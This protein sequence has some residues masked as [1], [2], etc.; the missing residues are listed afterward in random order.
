MVCL[1]KFGGIQR[2]CVPDA[3]KIVVPARG[4]LRAVGT[5]LKPTDLAGV[6]GQLGRLVLGNA[7]VVIEDEAAAG[8]RGQDMLVPAE[9]PHASIVTVHT[10]QFCALLD[11][12]D[13]NF[14]GAQADADISAVAAPLDAANVRVRRALK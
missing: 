1:G 4:E 12:P 13:L 2:A 5:P 3:D 11:I 6:G 9:S 8:T 14:P 10:A 7:H